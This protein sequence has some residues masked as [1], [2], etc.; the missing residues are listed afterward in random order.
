MR[1]RPKLSS[2]ID[3]GQA[4]NSECPL[5]YEPQDY[6]LPED[7]VNSFKGPYKL[8]KIPLLNFKEYNQDYNCDITYE[9]S[10]TRQW[11]QLI[12]EGEQQD[13]GIFQYNLENMKFGPLH[14]NNLMLMPLNE[15][16]N[17]VGNTSAN[18]KKDRNI[19]VFKLKNNYVIRRPPSFPDIKETIP[20]F[21][22]LT[23]QRGPDTLHMNVVKMKDSSDTDKNKIDLRFGVIS[24]GNEY[25]KKFAP[26][27]QCLELSI[28]NNYRVMYI[29][30]LQNTATY[31]QSEEKGIK[32]DTNNQQLLCAY[33]NTGQQ[34]KLTAKDL[35]EIT[36]QM[37]IHIGN[38]FALVLDDHMHFTYSEKITVG[39]KKLDGIQYISIGVINLALKGYTKYEEYIASLRPAFKFLADPLKN[40]K[41]T[42]YL[43]PLAYRYWAS[44]IP[45]KK[46]KHMDA[47]YQYIKDA[48]FTILNGENVEEFIVRNVRGQ[49]E[50]E[51]VQEMF[52]KT[53]ILTNEST[54]K[55]IFEF[56]TK[57]ENI[58]KT[59]VALHY[60][61]SDEGKYLGD[62]L[63]D[64]Y[65]NH[66]K[67][68][69]EETVTYF[70]IAII[71]SV[72]YK[73]E[74]IS[75]SN[76]DQRILDQL[77]RTFG[78][79]L[80]SEPKKVVFPEKFI[81]ECDSITANAINDFIPF[82]AKY[83][84]NNFLYKITDLNILK[85]ETNY[86]ITDETFK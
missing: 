40:K 80:D 3:F 48:L 43:H 26:A 5:M 68:I 53:N 22:I 24:N 73:K 45:G 47:K 74:D 39:S 51:E 18:Q 79:K 11:D 33:K 25:F 19:T 31:Y 52:P 7:S 66:H 62:K 44:R 21:S 78:E 65:I 54:F 56:I 42:R 63:R 15:P 72:V 75:K 10:G 46:V 69:D 30:I 83:V 61:K 71:K 59:I 16:L 6:L 85:W 2:V 1:D 8:K 60:F 9:Y 36:I 38:I 37:I 57:E 28:D 12:I 82:R 29:E 34:V 70:H 64:M 58:R 67:F 27:S 35:L 20:Y 77:K 55:E 86:T 49:K 17:L 41:N 81:Q 13:V 4:R 23:F 32:K 76:L 14:K 50:K 84:T